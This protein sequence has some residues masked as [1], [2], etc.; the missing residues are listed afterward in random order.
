MRPISRAFGISQ[1]YFTVILIQTF[2]PG[3]LRLLVMEMVMLCS[4]R[5]F[6]EL[7]FRSLNKSLGHWPSD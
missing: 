5:R 2:L 7:N 4:E 1:F 3:L 6:P